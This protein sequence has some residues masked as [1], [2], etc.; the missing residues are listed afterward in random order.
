MVDLNITNNMPVNLE[1]TAGVFPNEMKMPAKKPVELPLSGQKSVDMAP[2]EQKKPSEE[3][4]V[5]TVR[6][7]NKMM[8]DANQQM[9]FGIYEG[10]DQMYVQVIDVQSKRVVKMMPPENLL[11]L[12]TRLQ[13]AVGIV[14]DEEV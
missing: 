10:T 9:R 8:R 7:I 1:Q 3:D 4:I 14:L 5:S 6:D 11:S 13:E 2:E 12:R